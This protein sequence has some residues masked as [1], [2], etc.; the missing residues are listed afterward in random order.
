MR[1]EYI[2][3]RDLFDS[4]GKKKGRVR[5]VK[6]KERETAEV[7]LKCPECGFYEKRN[8]KWEPPFVKG[9]GKNQTFFIECKKCGF[10]TKL[11]KLRKLIKKK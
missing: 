4:K 7:E 10:K 8:E 1:I 11:L 3:T 2:T 9:S 6:F 5:I